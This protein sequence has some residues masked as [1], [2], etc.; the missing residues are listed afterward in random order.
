MNKDEN[1][2][3]NNGTADQGEKNPKKIDSRT[4]LFEFSGKAAKLC[5]QNGVNK[6]YVRE[7]I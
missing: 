6:I 4:L 7:L 5:Y 2:W 1:F 3:N